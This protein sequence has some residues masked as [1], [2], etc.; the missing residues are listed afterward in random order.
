[1]QSESILITPDGIMLAQ[2][3]T[4]TGPVEIAPGRSY[5]VRLRGYGPTARGD[6]FRML[7]F[8]SGLLLDGT[9]V[10]LRVITTDDELLNRLKL[11]DRATIHIDL[12]YGT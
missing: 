9:T 8:E 7:H 2:H 3:E 6:P 5:D 12:P 4:R 1:M 11:G 10:V